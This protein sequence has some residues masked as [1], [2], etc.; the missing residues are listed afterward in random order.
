MKA[1]AFAPLVMAEVIG[2]PMP[3]LLQQIMLVANHFC[4]ETGVWD[5]V[6]ASIPT[7]AGVVD[8]AVDAPSD[9]VV[10]RV[11]SVWLDNSELDPERLARPIANEQGPSTYN[12]AKSPRTVTLNR[13]PVAGQSLVVR[14]VYA[15]A[16]TSRV[17]PDFLMTDCHAAICAGV[18]GRLMAMQKQV[19]SNPALAPLYLN[20]YNA[21][22]IDARIDAERENVRGSLRVPPRRFG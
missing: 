8:Y 15:P 6:R 17:L 14:A 16:I 12:C 3:L 5:E 13:M 18:K 22:V 4:T 19:W 21:A 7:Q 11:R 20:E 1:D 2:C 10:V 9:A